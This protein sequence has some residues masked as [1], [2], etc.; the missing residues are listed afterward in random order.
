MNLMFDA[1]TYLLNTSFELVIVKS[2]DWDVQKREL[3]LKSENFIGKVMLS[4][5]TS[6]RGGLT[7]KRRESEK[8]IYYIHHHHRR[9]Y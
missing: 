5:I 4:H 8:Y 2:V 1:Y 9:R 6:L 7:S 3:I